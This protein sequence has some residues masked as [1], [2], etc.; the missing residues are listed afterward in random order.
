MKTFFDNKDALRKFLSQIKSELCPH[1]LKRT[2]LI[3]LLE[4]VPAR[5]Y[6]N[7]N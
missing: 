2:Y 6:Y 1:C 7:Y 3:V 5:D 4:F